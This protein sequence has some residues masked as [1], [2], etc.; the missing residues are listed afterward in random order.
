MVGVVDVPRP[1]KDGSPSTAK[2]AQ[3]SLLWAMGVDSNSKSLSDW[4]PDTAVVA[5]AI[6]EVVESGSTVVVRPGSGGR[7]LGIS[8][9]EGD[10]R[11]PPKWVYDAEELTTWARGVCDISQRR[12]GQA[13]D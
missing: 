3:A 12:K 9:W 10:T 13:A 5:Q 4:D 11:H 2:S 6:L 8:I 7:A 1:N